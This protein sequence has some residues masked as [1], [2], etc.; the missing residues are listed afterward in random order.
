MYF[1]YGTMDCGKTAMAIM[2]A[3]EFKSKGRNVV[4]LKPQIDTRSRG[5]LLDSRVGIS[6]ECIDILENQRIADIVPDKPF[7][8]LL[9]VDEAQFLTD[10]QV[11]DIKSNVR[12]DL[13]IL[14]GLKNNYLGKLFSGSKSI[15][16]VADSIREI[17]SRCTICRKKATQN[18]RFNDDKLVTEGKEIDIGG[19]EKYKPLCFDCFELLKEKSRCENIWLDYK[20]LW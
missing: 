5:N 7:T 9:I 10:E 11:R 8:D 15:L 4:V 16:E 18:G 13:A 2:K 3:Y 12:V 19:N 20:Y 17:P 1:Y 6:I 14:Y